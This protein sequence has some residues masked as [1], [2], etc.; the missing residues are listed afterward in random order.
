[1]K[2]RWKNWRGGI[3]SSDLSHGKRVRVREGG[4]FP[5]ERRILAGHP[6]PRGRPRLIL[7]LFGGIPNSPCVFLMEA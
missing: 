5:V 4:L 7:L 1:M 3:V 6:P 2:L